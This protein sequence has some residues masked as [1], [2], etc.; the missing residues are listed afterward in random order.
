MRTTCTFLVP[1]FEPS[2]WAPAIETGLPVG[3][4]HM[5]K[6]F[7]GGLEG[8]SVTSFTGA[9]DPAKGIGT[10]IAMESIDGT[11]DGR[12]GAFNLVHS[13]TTRG[14][15]NERLHEFVLI[16]PGSGTGDLAGITG[17]GALRITD[18]GTHHLDLD[19]ELDATAP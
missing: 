7:S 16:V 10:Y 6:R 9:F 4:A 3:E 11:L 5:T 2:D 12:R 18:D 13:A 19:Y 1:D 8:H 15:G 17:T 14:E